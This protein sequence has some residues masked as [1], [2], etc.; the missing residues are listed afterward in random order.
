MYIKLTYCRESP[1]AFVYIHSPGETMYF[2]SKYCCQFEEI[3]YKI[4]QVSVY[5]DSS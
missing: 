5:V 3:C 2:I 1:T 4:T